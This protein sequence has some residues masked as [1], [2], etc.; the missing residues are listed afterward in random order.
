[1][2]NGKNKFILELLK[3]QVN[4]GDKFKKQNKNILQK[5]RIQTEMAFL[6][7]YSY[8]NNISKSVLLEKLEK[9]PGSADMKLE[10][11]N[12][13]NCLEYIP[14]EDNT[15][16]FFYENDTTS[17][18][19]SGQLSIFKNLNEQNKI[20]LAMDYFLT[21]NFSNMIM[22]VKDNDKYRNNYFFGFLAHEK[23]EHKNAYIG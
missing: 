15:D 19:I 14:E 5:G 22:K 7:S 8:K 1:M 11:K 16:D 2:E 13:I 12:T 3:K 23:N 18:Y 21:E 6:K 4:D 17:D 9:N 20:S 10:I